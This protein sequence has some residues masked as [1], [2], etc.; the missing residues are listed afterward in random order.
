MRT[1][2]KTRLLILLLTLVVALG[3]TL[4]WSLV[5][6]NNA[7][8]TTGSAALADSGS[9]FI[10]GEGYF[11]YQHVPM[12]WNGT[13]QGV[14]FTTYS[15]P[16]GTVTGPVAYWLTLTFADGSQEQLQDV[17]LLSTGQI[18]IDLTQH[19]DPRAGVM[20]VVQNEGGGLTF[21]EYYLVSTP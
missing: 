20:I 16:G 9:I 11:H 18:D 14:T 10:R 1:D 4:A 21:E 8:E 17:G 15:P 13:I 7:G 2:V 19:N 6:D 12:F 3:A 5:R